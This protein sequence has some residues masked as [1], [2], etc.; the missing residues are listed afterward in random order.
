M[1]P[2]QCRALHWCMG[3]KK[4][5]M[6][7]TAIDSWPVQHSMWKEPSGPQYKQ[8]NMV[9]QQ[10]NIDNWMKYSDYNE[11][12]LNKWISLYLCWVN[13]GLQAT[14][15]PQNQKLWAIIVIW[16]LLAFATK[17][18]CNKNEITIMYGWFHQKFAKA[19]HCFSCLF[20]KKNLIMK[21]L[22]LK[23]EIYDS[24]AAFTDHRINPQ[25]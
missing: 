1:W 19:F 16:K 5:L 18:K 7:S 8:A 17:W 23:G 10:T 4:Q 14:H 3:T 22:F 15:G 13:H 12:E 9:C 21:K 20:T 6:C 2:V 11:T 25:I 24:S